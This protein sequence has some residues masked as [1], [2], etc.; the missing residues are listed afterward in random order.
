MVA[1]GGPLNLDARRGG[2]GRRGGRPFLYQRIGCHTTYIVAPISC[3][4]RSS[5]HHMLVIVAALMPEQK[6]GAITSRLAAQSSLSDEVSLLTQRHSSWC[7]RF[8]FSV[9]SPR[10]QEPILCDRD[11][12]LCA[13]LRHSRHYLCLRHVLC[14][15]SAPFSFRDVLLCQNRP[16]LHQTLSFASE[17]SNLQRSPSILQDKRSHP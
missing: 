1:N 15:L 4:S 7:C 5:P 16:S 17:V 11:A 6:T 10:C 2:G 8:P 14:L 9:R 12:F 13:C 3:K